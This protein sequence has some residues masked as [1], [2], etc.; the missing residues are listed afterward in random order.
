MADIGM[1]YIIMAYMIMAYTVMAYI[2]TAY[3][4]MAQIIMAYTVMTYIIMAYTVMAYIILAYIVMA[5]DRAATRR[6]CTSMWPRRTKR[7]QATYKS[8]HPWLAIPTNDNLQN[9][10]NDINDNTYHY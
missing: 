8:L 6:T 10:N 9:I 3:T 5:Y 4:V 1:A 2:I 7:P